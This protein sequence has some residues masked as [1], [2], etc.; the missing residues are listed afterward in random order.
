MLLGKEVYDNYYFENHFYMFKYDGL[1]R[2]LLLDYKFNEKSYLFRTFIQI[3]EKYY[4]K[5]YLQLDF[6]DIIIPVPM[7]KKRMK[8][9]GYNQSE[10]FAKKVSEITN[11]KLNKKAL[12][13]LKN[14]T[15]QSLLDKNSRLQNVQNMYKINEKENIKDK[16]ILLIDDIF[17]TGSTVNECSKIL[18]QAGACKIDVFTLAK[19]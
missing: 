5:E 16:K 12:I 6:Y 10:L 3:F 18:K 15:A 7:S 11:I 4:K 19:D 8:L 2:K 9:R 1:I 17:T 14:N 13:K